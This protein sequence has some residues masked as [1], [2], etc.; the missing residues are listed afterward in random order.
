MGVCGVETAE[1]EGGEWEWEW[2]C[3]EDV[4]AGVRERGWGERGIRCLASGRYDGLGVC[5]D[6]KL[7]VLS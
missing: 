1:A 6:K 3:G 5:R 7:F 4:C 2:E